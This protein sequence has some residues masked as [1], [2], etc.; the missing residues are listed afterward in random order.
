MVMDVAPL[1]SAFSNMD[2]NIFTRKLFYYN[3]AIMWIVAQKKKKI[4]YE[5][6]LK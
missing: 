3:F 2:K 1:L 6:F 5:Q 4:L